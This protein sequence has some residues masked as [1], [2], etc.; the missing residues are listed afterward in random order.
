MR[1]SFDVEH[2]RGKNLEIADA[3]SR[4]A[5]QEQKTKDFLSVDEVNSF[6]SGVLSELG[7]LDHFRLVAKEQAKDKT[8]RTLCH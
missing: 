7:D 8:C 1:F 3:L 5:I 6:V 2:V 4:A